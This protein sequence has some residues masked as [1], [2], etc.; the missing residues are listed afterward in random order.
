MTP[1]VGEG[2][3]SQRHRDDDASWKPKLKNVIGQCRV[4]RVKLAR[5]RLTFH[6]FVL[7]IP[8][9][10]PFLLAVFFKS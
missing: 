6:Q 10:L 4:S 3:P 9:P 2:Q 5:A 7:C 1:A 8:T